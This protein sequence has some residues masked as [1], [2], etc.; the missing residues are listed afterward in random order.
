MLQYKLQ[1][2]GKTDLRSNQVSDSSGPSHGLR[3]PVSNMKS[4]GMHSQEWRIRKKRFQRSLKNYGR[5]ESSE[6]YRDTYD[7][8]S[9]TDHMDS[10]VKKIQRG[11]TY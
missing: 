6:I 1:D 3:D 9:T 2:S 10:V 8:K 5:G 7:K 11:M 4:E